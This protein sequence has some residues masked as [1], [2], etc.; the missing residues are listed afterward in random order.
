MWIIPL[1]L[2]VRVVRL[3]VG[4]AEGD[5]SFG[6]SKKSNV[7]SHFVAS[8]YKAIS[9][10]MWRCYIMAKQV[11]SAFVTNYTTASSGHSLAPSLTMSS[12]PF[13]V[14]I[15]PSELLNNTLGRISV[16]RRVSWPT[17]RVNWM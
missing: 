4:K 7:T 11:A 16:P 6:L 9:A 17:W 15:M 5:H 8:M 14:D 13:V 12:S 2:L 3:W 1:P 10:H